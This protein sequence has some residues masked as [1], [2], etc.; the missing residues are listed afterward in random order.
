MF[1]QT[2]DAF[3]FVRVVSGPRWHFYNLCRVNL[4]ERTFTW[5]MV[6]QQ[7]WF[8]RHLGMCFK[9]TSEQL[10]F[11]RHLGISPPVLVATRASI[12]ESRHDLFWWPLTWMDD[13]VINGCFLLCYGRRSFQTVILLQSHSV[14]KR[15]WTA[16]GV[17]FSQWSHFP[18]LIWGHVAL[19]AD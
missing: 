18:L 15:T 6:H 11:W 2:T 14:L 13:A 9:E 4:D 3:P 12:F 8:V 10:C 1:V 17:S 16:D 5:G 19:A 7:H